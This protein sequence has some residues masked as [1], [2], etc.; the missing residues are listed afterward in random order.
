MVVQEQPQAPKSA[1]ATSLIR[2]KS[3]V[4]KHIF[5]GNVK[6]D[7]NEQATYSDIF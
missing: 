7:I 4:I 6:N 1:I 5:R 3:T 2:I